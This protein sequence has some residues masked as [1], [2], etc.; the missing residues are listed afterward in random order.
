MQFLI[1]EDLPR[2]TGDLLRSY[3]HKAIDVRDIGLRGERVHKLLPM[4]KVEICV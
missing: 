3:G 4:L 1:D 2:S